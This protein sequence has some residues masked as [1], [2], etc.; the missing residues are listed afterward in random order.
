MSNLLRRWCLRYITPSA[1]VGKM[2]NQIAGAW[3][4]GAM[5]TLQQ[6]PKPAIRS[7]TRTLNDQVFE[8]G[9]FVT[10]NFAVGVS[11]ILR[12]DVPVVDTRWLVTFTQLRRSGPVEILNR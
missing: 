4:V 3:F 11:V 8:P 5:S 12:T 2:L 1:R 7:D 9:S 10:D 6:Q